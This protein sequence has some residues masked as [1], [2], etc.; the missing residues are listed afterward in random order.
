MQEYDVVLKLLLR[1]SA[2]LALDELAGTTIARWL[3]VELPE[4]VN[5]RVDL[6][7]ETADGILIQIELQ[8][9]PDNTMAL[10]MAEYSLAIYRL[11]QRRTFPRQI[12][13]YVGEPPLNMEDT[14]VGPDLQ[15]RYRLIDV[16][17]LDGERLRQSPEMGDNVIAILTR[18]RDQRDALNEI[19]GKLSNL[20]IDGREFYLRALLTLA[21]LRG[22][23]ETVEEEARKMPL[24][25]DI[26]D[27]RV[28]GREFKRGLE[29]GVQQGLQQGELTLLRRQIEER[30]GPIPQWAEDRLATRS[31]AELEELAV[32]VLKAKTLE[33]LFA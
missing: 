29:Q 31:A 15:F 10:R 18:L 11:L 14:L 19:L 5:R 20:D 16:R 2:K 23:E 22:L 12:V 9:G 3:N 28:L 24:L 25:N 17:D 6:L 8:S 1:G 4:V 30:F 27:N 26:L 13:L 32:R 21:G 33:E 7:G